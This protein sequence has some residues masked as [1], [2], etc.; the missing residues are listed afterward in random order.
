MDWK[1]ASD[2]YLAE[3]WDPSLA[4]F[5][6]WSE[7]IFPLN[8][9]QLIQVPPPPLGATEN[10]II[11][12]VAL[13]GIRQQ[14]QNLIWHEATVESALVEPFQQIVQCVLDPVIYTTIRAF[15]V[16][17]AM[18]VFY[19][20]RLYSRTRPFQVDGTLG[21]V[22]PQGSEHFPKHPSYPSSHATQATIV[23][24]VIKFLLDPYGTPESAEKRARIDQVAFLIGFR[25]EIAGLHFRSDTTAGISLGRQI[26]TLLRQQPTLACLLV[27]AK[28][29]FAILNG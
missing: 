23:A 16:E 26:F 2:F 6:T 11:E 15:I 28:R 27:A 7:S 17:E 10:E 21:T 24:E 14:N 12:L 5:S 18:P 22:I 13:K 3:H 29:R 9:T 20:K 25:R 4:P 8:W 1:T 19:F